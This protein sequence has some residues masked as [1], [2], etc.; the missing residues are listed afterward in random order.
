MLFKILLPIFLPS[1]THPCT[2]PLPPPP[3]YI[4]VQIMLIW[5]LSCL[6]NS[7]F[8]LAHGY[9]KKPTI[10]TGQLWSILS[11]QR[12]IRLP[13]FSI[14]PSVFTIVS[15]KTGQ[16]QE[17]RQ[18]RQDDGTYHMLGL[19]LLQRHRTLAK[20]R[21]CIL[22]SLKSAKIWPT[23]LQLFEVL[24]CK[25]GRVSGKRKQWKPNVCTPRLITVLLIHSQHF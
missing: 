11:N 20:Y 7:G 14:L 13:L 16:A 8:S 15:A 24:L 10:L 18:A 2:I 9:V 6:Q 23:R 1:L 17:K 21:K 4:T 5:A 25:A 22:V 19:Q 3:T 12:P